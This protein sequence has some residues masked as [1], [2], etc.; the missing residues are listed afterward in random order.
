MRVIG[1]SNPHCITIEASDL[2]AAELE[3]RFGSSEPAPSRLAGDPLV[4][5]PECYLVS[6][7]TREPTR[8]ST[9]FT[10]SIGSPRVGAFATSSA[11]SF[12]C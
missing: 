5:A 7:R 11:T 10:T 9:G 12:S 6:R 2:A 3:H 4:F 8:L 1:G